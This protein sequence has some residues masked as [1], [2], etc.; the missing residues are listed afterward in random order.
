MFDSMILYNDDE[1]EHKIQ[2]SNN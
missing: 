1:Y 2:P